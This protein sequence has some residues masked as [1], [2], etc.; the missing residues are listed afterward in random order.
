MELAGKGIYHHMELSQSIISGTH[1]PDSL[2]RHVQLYG[3]HKAWKIV[4]DLSYMEAGKGRK[5]SITH[6]VITVMHQCHQSS[7]SGGR[8]VRH[9]TTQSVI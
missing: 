4:G 6:Q 8:G 1:T 7:L 3:R 2:P 5:T 9:G